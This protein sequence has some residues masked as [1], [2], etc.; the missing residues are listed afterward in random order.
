MIVGMRMEATPMAPASFVS[1]P[2]HIYAATKTATI[3][4]TPKTNTAN[5]PTFPALGSTGMS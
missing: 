3:D 4:N 2:V 1:A 5:T